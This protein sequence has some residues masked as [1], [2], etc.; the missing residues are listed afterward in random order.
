LRIPSILLLGSKINPQIENTDSEGEEEQTTNKKIFARFLNF[1]RFS[2]TQPGEHKRKFK[3]FF[4]IWEKT[5]EL[6][7]DFPA[8][9]FGQITD[10]NRP[11]APH[12]L[13]L[14]GASVP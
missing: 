14:S 1:G 7:F 8:K 2:L 6:R 12:N 9:F 10:C 11:E 13:R 5:S 4:W 3:V